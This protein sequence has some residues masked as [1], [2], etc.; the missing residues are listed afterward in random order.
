MKKDKPIYED[1]RVSVH[2]ASA[3][4]AKRWVIKQKADAI[5]SAFIK[6]ISKRKNLGKED[7]QEI[8]RTL[9]AEHER[10]L[11]HFGIKST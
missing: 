2:F 10:I 4:E 5:R 9:D 3:E 8:M 7:R 6:V 11:K 1:D